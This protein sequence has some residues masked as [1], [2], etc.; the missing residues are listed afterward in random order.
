MPS[1]REE[2]R[3]Q[4]VNCGPARHHLDHRVEHRGG[5]TRLRARPMDRVANHKTSRVT[6][7]YDR[8]G[9]AEEDRRLMA[10]VARLLIGLVE[11]TK[12]TNVVS[13]R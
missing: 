10:A 6:D 13:L 11:G 1:D 3:Q 5:R 9:Y 12:T 4:S 7:V 8:H 2:R